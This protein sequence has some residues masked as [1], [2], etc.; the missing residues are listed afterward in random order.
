MIPKISNFICHSGVVDSTIY[1]AGQRFS[2]NCKNLIE[3]NL[4]WLHYPI[5]IGIGFLMLTFLVLT[6]SLGELI[7]TYFKNN[8]LIIK[9][10]LYYFITVILYLI[11]MIKI[12]NLDAI[13]K[14]DYI[15]TVGLSAYITLDSIIIVWA[16]YY[17]ILQYVCWKQKKLEQKKKEHED[18]TI[19]NIYLK[20]IF[21]K[22][23]SFRYFNYFTLT[24]G[25]II[26]AY[27]LYIGIMNRI[28]VYNQALMVFGVCIFYIKYI[29]I[30]DFTNYFKF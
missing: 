8:R 1:E 2:E 25:A 21:N 27:L 17:S 16:L 14:N 29:R 23:K 6:F 7:E 15:L 5:L 26:C 13:T 24:T 12:Y 4:D 11:C 18:G 10:V 19:Y 28:T 3:Q 20:I 30:K 22:V 9:V